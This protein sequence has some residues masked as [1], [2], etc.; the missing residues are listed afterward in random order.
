MKILNSVDYDKHAYLFTFHLN[1]FTEIEMSPNAF[2][3]PSKKKELRQIFSADIQVCNVL[4]S[5]HDSEEYACELLPHAGPEHRT[6]F[7]LLIV[8]RSPNLHTLIWFL[9]NERS[10]LFHNCWRRRA[11]TAVI[12]IIPHDAAAPKIYY[13]LIVLVCSAVGFVQSHAVEEGTS[14]ASSGRFLAKMLA[15]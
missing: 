1:I 2:T 4:L 15:A 3:I 9:D 5:L 12:F 7:I 8:L 14:L 11:A 13:V 10:L 6:M